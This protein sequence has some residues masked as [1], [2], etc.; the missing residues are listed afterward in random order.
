R[1]T[2]DTGDAAVRPDRDADVARSR[3]QVVA[4]AHLGRGSGAGQR[5]R[6]LPGDGTD[7][8]RPHGPAH[9][10]RCDRGRGRSTAG[11][12]TVA[13]AQPSG[14]R[15]RGT[16]GSAHLGR[17]AGCRRHD[18]GAGR[19]RPRR[20]RPGVRGRSA[21]RNTHGGG[22]IDR[23]PSPPNGSRARAADVASALPRH[24]PHC[25]L[26][27]R[28]TANAGRRMR[29]LFT[30]I[31]HTTHFHSMVPLAWAMRLAGHEVRVAAQPGLAETLTGAGLTAVPLGSDHTVWE[32]QAALAGQPGDAPRIDFTD[33]LDG[34]P[35]FAD[36]LGLWTILT[37]TVFAPLNDLFVDELTEYA[38]HWKPDLVLWEPFTYAGGVAATVCGAR[39]ARLLWGADV[40]GR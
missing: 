36:L 29:V 4:R 6:P 8:D 5:A 3:R 22:R 23:P 11:A 21:A 25:T 34:A 14:A 18:G 37:P 38:Q 26:G 20:G 16:G 27:G 12:S 30:C 7:A 9:G 33:L 35:D 1:R 17:R 39:H 15:R 28:V 32:H 13:T 2:V 31:D 10:R 24:L 40:L 19:V